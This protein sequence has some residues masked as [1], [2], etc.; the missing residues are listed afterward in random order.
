MFATAGR[1]SMPFLAMAARAGR[2]GHRGFGHG[3]GGGWGHG[4]YGH[5][6]LPPWLRGF[7]P[8]GG[9]GSRRRGR[10]DVRLALLGI[11]AEAPMHG[12]QLIREIA[13][14]SEG[15][16]R[17]SPGSVYPTLSQLEDEGL[18]HAEQS[19]GRRVFDLTD[20]GRTEVSER[21]EEFDALWADEDEASWQQHGDL[22]GLVMQVGG[23]AMQVASAG[24]DDQREQAAE[25]LEDTR[26]SLYRLL[27]EEDDG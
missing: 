2:H 11:L 22:A 20:E 3:W 7:P 26:R 19:G 4:G 9:P 14:R 25:I 27:A 21:A 23:A 5:P 15:R 17:V 18:V 6:G 12:Y 24:T 8:F 1:R 16:W 10:G 13:Q